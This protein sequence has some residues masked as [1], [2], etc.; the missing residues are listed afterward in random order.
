MQI[1]M[2]VAV[3]DIIQIGDHT[4]IVLESQ[5]HEVTFKICSAEEAGEAHMRPTNPR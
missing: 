2:D 5:G 3:G 4:L 1:E